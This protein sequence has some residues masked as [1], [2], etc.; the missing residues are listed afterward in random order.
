MT[1]SYSFGGGKFSGGGNFRGDTVGEP[2]DVR[3]RVRVGMGDWTGAGDLLNLIIRI[4]QGTLGVSHVEG[5]AIKVQSKCSIS[6]IRVVF[7][8]ILQV[9]FCILQDFKVFLR[10][11]LLASGPGCQAER[12]ILGFRPSVQL[13][14]STPTLP[15]GRGPV[16]TDPSN[17]SPR[18]TC[19]RFL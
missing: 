9:F 5:P 11:Q 6:Q 10:V 1:P 14:I 19:V 7:F 12:R 13:P 17:L 2:S 15:R 4:L 3:G 18:K 16:F 8:C